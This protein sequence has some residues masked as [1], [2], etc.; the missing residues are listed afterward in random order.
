MYIYHCCWM[1]YKVSIVP[2]ETRE[3]VHMQTEVRSFT[4]PFRWWGADFP[5]APLSNVTFAHTSEHTHIAQIWK[6]HCFCLFVLLLLHKCARWA[7]SLLF[8]S[9]HP[10]C[11]PLQYSSSFHSLSFCL[12]LSLCWFFTV[13]SSLYAL[14]FTPAPLTFPTHSTLPSISPRLPWLC[15]CVW[16]FTKGMGVDWWFRTDTWYWHCL[17]MWECVTSKLGFWG[18]CCPTQWGVPSWECTQWSFCLSLT[19]YYSHTTF[20]SGFSWFFVAEKKKSSKSLQAMAAADVIQQVTVK[21][22]NS[23]KQTLLNVFLHPCK[24]RQIRRR[25]VCVCLCLCVLGWQ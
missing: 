6:C 16:C 5:L 12:P 15:V 20:V 21:C 18:G 14:P 8:T 9:S 23:F 7:G 19:C 24:D 17:T 22:Q 25:F 10:L 1:F 13:R 2:F 11:P 4:S 3:V